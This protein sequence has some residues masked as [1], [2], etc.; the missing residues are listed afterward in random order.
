MSKTELISFIAED[1]GL[2]KAD[3]AKA[4]EAMQKGVVEGLKESG[5]VTITGFLIFTAKHKEAT[6]GRNPRTGNP[7]DI[8]ARTAIGIKAGSTLKDALNN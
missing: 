5:K 3:A 6:V 8:P 7:V 2:T 4:L 1:A